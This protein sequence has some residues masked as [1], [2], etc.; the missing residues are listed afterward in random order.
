MNPTLESYF[1]DQHTD[2]EITTFIREQLILQGKPAKGEGSSCF[3]RK[4]GLKCAVGHLI[5]DELY[6]PIMEGKFL[7]GLLSRYSAELNIPSNISDHKLNY[8][9]D[10]QQIHDQFP[11]D[12]DIPFETYI[13][14][15]MR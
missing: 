8:L 4:D 11:V 14:V 3:Y 10:L 13:S 6:Q 12:G 1:K 2:E 5:P 9:R 15:K 7:D